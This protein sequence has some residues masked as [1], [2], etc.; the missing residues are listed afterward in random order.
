MEPK[1]FSQLVAKL[2]FRTIDELD[3]LLYMCANIYRITGAD[4]YW[5]LITHISMEINNRY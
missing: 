3:E 2:P 1:Q 4:D 5:R